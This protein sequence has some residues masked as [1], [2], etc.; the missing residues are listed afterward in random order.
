MNFDFL[1]RPTET[2]DHLLEGL[3]AAPRSRLRC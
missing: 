2:L 3:F 1:F